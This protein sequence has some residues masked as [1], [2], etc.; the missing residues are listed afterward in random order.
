MKEEEKEKETISFIY[1]FIYS[2]IY[3]FIH[4]FIHLFIYLFIYSREL[5]LETEFIYARTLKVEIKI[6]GKPN[7][8][9]Y[10]LFHIPVL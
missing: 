5:D 2:S 6:P 1:S 8:D 9:K 3:L 7:S 4:S 10:L